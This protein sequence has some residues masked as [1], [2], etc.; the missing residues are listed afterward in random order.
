MKTA[1]LEAKAP[2]IPRNVLSPDAAMAGNAI[3]V[4]RLSGCDTGIAVRVAVC[5]LLVTGAFVPSS[6]AQQTSTPVP[7]GVVKAERKPVTPSLDFVGRVDAINRVEIKARVTGFLE[8]VLFKE[9]DAVNEGAPLYRI[10]K[11]LFQDA[12]QQA[13]G[14]LERSKAAKELSA[15]QLQRAQ[16]LLDKNA[17]T[18]VARD[19]QKAADDQAAGQ[20]TSDEASLSTAKINLGY[21]DI[22][23]PIAGKASKTNITKGNLVGPDTGTLT[24]IV[25]QDPM[26]VTFPVSQRDFLRARETGTKLDVGAI[27][28]S[29][30]FADGTIYDQTGRI[31]FVD[32]TVDRTTDTVL[33]RATFP[34][35]ASGLIDGQFV[36]VRV[37]LEG[38]SVKEQIVVPQAALIA[39]QEGVYVFVVEGGK[40]IVKRVKPLREVGA[41]VA[42]E[43]A[44]NGD[45]EVIVQGLQAVHPGGPVRATPL[46]PVLNQ[47][48]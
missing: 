5:A 44:L 34:N 6:R 11:G 32:V 30:R 45:E 28:A 3:Y 37:D 14:A 29:L 4:A 48:G 31:N 8:A 21:T 2:P 19:Q 23:S 26:Y 43:S 22:V 17:G 42:V 1:V 35:P 25:S 20:I 47:G 16:E 33:V 18:V 10:E 13:E 24:T 9:G 39:D 41:G 40:A 12:V 27:K 15:V 7:V 38:G 36:R 46:Q